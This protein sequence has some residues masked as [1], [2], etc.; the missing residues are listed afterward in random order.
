[1]A[2]IF[3]RSFPFIRYE[4]RE[5]AA[6]DKSINDLLLSAL[7]N[8]RPVTKEEALNIP[9]VAGC[10]ELIAGKV[11]SIPI[12]LYKEEDGKVIEIQD[13]RVDLLNDDTKDTL[14]GYQ[15]KKALVLDYLLDGNGYAYIN[16]DRNKIKSLHY[17]DSRYV[18]IRMN[19]DPIFK[20]YDFI[21]HGQTFRDFEF[22]KFTRKTK[23]GVTGT[24]II[25][26][27]NKILSVAY[28]A[29]MYE[30]L[31]NRTG[32]NKKG[33][34][35]SQSRLSKESIEELKRSWNN[36]YQNNTENVV[37]LN[38][39]IEFQ[40]ASQSSVELQMNENKQ[41]NSALISFLF[42]T[43]P[44]ILN[45]TA[46]EEVYNA[47]VENCIMPIL[48]SFQTALNKDLLLEKEKEQSFYFAF[49]TKHLLK[50]DIEKRF[51]AYEIAVRNGFMQVD[52]IR[53]EEDLPPLG[54]NFLKLG[55]QDVLYDPKTKQIYTPNTNKTAEIGNMESTL[56]GGETEGED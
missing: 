21:V 48:E 45:G 23:D 33:F 28:N 42:L 47:W 24:G 29:L 31:L 44:S 19:S 53:Y 32:G 38:N 20:S 8:D 16:R 1:M 17:V 35:K 51:K 49:D 37:V 30:D 27:N 6:D 22:L 13:E 46:K 14:D 56:E 2:I 52:E 3:K 12:K 50:S 40:E 55:L 15:L 4:K 18:T 39:G 26:E 10:A 11:A 34:L 54:L 9:A 36:L 41:T 43:P 5:Q 25:E 7:I